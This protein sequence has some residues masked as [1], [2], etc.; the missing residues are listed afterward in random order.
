MASSQP[1]FRTQW[2]AKDEGSLK[3]IWTRR[4]ADKLV[5]GDVLYLVALNVHS[6][7][8]VIHFSKDYQVQGIVHSLVEFGGRRLQVLEEDLRKKAQE[9]E[10]GLSKRTDLVKERNHLSTYLGGRPEAVH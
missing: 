9:T 4:T 8:D 2:L 6:M 3:A 7:S 1:L 10:S 5:W